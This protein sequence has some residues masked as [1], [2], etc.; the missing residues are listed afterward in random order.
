MQQ[1]ALTQIFGCHLS[2]S[3]QGSHQVTTDDDLY[4]LVLLKC[5]R[6]LCKL[7]QDS[8]RGLEVT[9]YNI[10]G[11]VTDIRNMRFQVSN[12]AKSVARSKEG[13]KTGVIYLGII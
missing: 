4:S 11:N 5:F 7:A 1:D 8:I 9:Q 6:C 13:E 10:K 3:W 2:G 12:I